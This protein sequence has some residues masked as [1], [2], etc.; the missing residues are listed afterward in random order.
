[1]HF[2]LIEVCIFFYYQTVL[3]TQSNVN[4][5]YFVWFVKLYYD[6]RMKILDRSLNRCHAVWKTIVGKKFKA[7]VKSEIWLVISVGIPS[8]LLSWR[9]PFF[10]ICKYCL[11]NFL[12]ELS[13]IPLY[14][15]RWGVSHQKSMRLLPVYTEKTYNLAYNSSVCL[16]FR[17]CCRMCKCLESRE[18]ILLNSLLVARYGRFSVFSCPP[19]FSETTPEMIWKIEIIKIL[20][21]TRN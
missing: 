11:T 8:I 9:R 5:P 17:I 21:L 6:H 18:I 3:C 13:P 14:K 2:F 20:C 4:W 12:F 7:D 19:F 1:M 10:C 16:R 15:A